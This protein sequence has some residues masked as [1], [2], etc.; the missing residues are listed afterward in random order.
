MTTKINETTKYHIE[1]VSFC[2]ENK[3][4]HIQALSEKSTS[5]I[6]IKLQW[7]FKSRPKERIMPATSFES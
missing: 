3:Q 2:P 6:I 1:D 4:N 7:I 5:I